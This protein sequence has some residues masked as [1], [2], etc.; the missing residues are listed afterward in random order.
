LEE[1]VRESGMAGS[2][3]WL[4]RDRPKGR[5]LGLGQIFRD[6]NREG[7]GFDEVCISKAS[8]CRRI[9]WIERDGLLEIRHASLPRTSRASIKHEAGLAKKL[10]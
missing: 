6:W 5:S 8:V 4:E 7:K 10:L 9:G 3:L 1:E 2:Q